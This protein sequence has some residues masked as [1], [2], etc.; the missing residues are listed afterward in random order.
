MTRRHHNTYVVALRSLAVFLVLVALAPV[1]RADAPR[2]AFTERSIKGR[3]GFS[4]EFGMIV[5]PAA[6]TQPVPTAALG[7]VV[8]DGR[9]GC[10]VTTT[11]NINGTIV[12]PLASNT[13]AYSVN[14]DGTGTSV[15]EFPGTPF[16]G[17]STVAFVIVDRN[18]EIRFINTNA[19]VAGFTARR[20]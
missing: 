3:W 20:Q 9:G 12:G 11:I 13:C 8:F 16:D 10:L 19:I 14:A 5:P 17:P 18:R 4:G 15:A 1:S 7:T 6:H 2:P